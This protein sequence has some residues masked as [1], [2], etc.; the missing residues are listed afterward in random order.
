MCDSRG[1][2]LEIFPWNSGAQAADLKKNAAY[3]V[4]PD[5]YIAIAVDD[6]DPAKISA[7]L[8]KWVKPRA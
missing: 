1:L 8:E 7:Y 5:G 3:V 2:Q 6:A 4:R